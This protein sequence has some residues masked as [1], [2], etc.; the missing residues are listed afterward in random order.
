MLS[1]PN[2]L[3]FPLLLVRPLD[4]SDASEG[5]RDSF[6]FGLGGGLREVFRG[7]PLRVEDSSDADEKCFELLGI[8][9]N[10]VGE[11]ADRPYLDVFLRTTLGGEL[12]LLV[13]VAT[14]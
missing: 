13:G 11:A 8:G 3:K 7:E 10:I 1:D 12:A 5:R 6:P 2:S 14:G 9:G 4:S